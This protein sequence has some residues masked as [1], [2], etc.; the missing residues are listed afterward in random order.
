MV[1]QPTDYDACLTVYIMR[2]TIDTCCM[3]TDDEAKGK[4]ADLQAYR[5]SLKVSIVLQSDCD[6]GW[7]KSDIQ[8]SA[9]PSTLPRLTRFMRG[10][11]VETANVE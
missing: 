11:R 6:C 1:F 3:L 10:A 2:P 7:V 5:V 8:G 9:K 4:V